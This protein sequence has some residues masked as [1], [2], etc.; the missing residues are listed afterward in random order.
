MKA[1]NEQILNSINNTGNVPESIY[2]AVR[3]V[4]DAANLAAQLKV[5]KTSHHW[6]KKDWGVFCN[7]VRARINSMKTLI[8][9][10]IF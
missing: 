3:S 10:I 2:N 1:T 5:K 6:N 8:E 4:E 7:E 9:D